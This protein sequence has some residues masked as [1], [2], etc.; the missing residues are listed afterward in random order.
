MLN[1]AQGG[2]GE[3]WLCLFWAWSLSSFA[4]IVFVTVETNKP[5]S[6]LTFDTPNVR[7]WPIAAVGTVEIAATPY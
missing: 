2:N 6:G 4:F 7:L 1:W 5:G 3:C